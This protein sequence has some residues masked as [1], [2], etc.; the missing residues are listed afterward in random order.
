M[1][2]KF[3]WAANAE[4]QPDSC[5]GI[6]AR[7]PIRYQEHMDNDLYYSVPVTNVQYA[8]KT[9][10]QDVKILDTKHFGKCLIMDNHMQSAQSDEAIYHESLVHP[11]LLS[12]PNPK[13]VFIAGGGEG[14]TLREVL[15]HGSVETV[16]MVDL[17]EPAVDLCRRMLPEWSDGGFSDKRV[18]L[19]YED[20]DAFLKKNAG[21]DKYDVII[22]DI[23]DPLDGGPAWKLYS[24][25]FYKRIK[26]ENLKLNGVMCTQSTSCSL[27]LVTECF[28]I[29]NKTLN[30]VFTHVEPYRVDVPSFG[31][32]WGFHLCADTPVLDRTTASDYINTLLSKRLKADGCQDPAEALTHYDGDCHSHMFNLSKFERRACYE[33]TRLFTL[34]KPFFIA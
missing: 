28:T 3:S 15:R 7:S 5:T 1:F 17:D 34:K 13:R 26:E 10:F 11:A 2:N 8:G 20:A 22:M 4:P 18:T 29:I 31:C 23:C 19:Y 14:A 24:T 12:H 27:N 33:E 21:L 32:P 25:E 30:S 9:E 16:V 6:N